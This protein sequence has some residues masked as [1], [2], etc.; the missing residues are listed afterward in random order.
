MAHQGFTEAPSRR[1][2]RAYLV[3]WAVGAVGALGYLATLA[4][5]PEQLAPVPP[6]KVVQ[7]NPGLEAATQALAEVGTIKQTVDSL[8]RNV[9][10]LKDSV[11]QRGDT[12]KTLQSRLAALEEKVAAIPNGVAT[13][14]VPMTNKQKLAEKAQEKAQQKAAAAAK[15]NPPKAG[16]RVI[17]ITE[18]PAG[19]ITPTTAVKPPIETGSITQPTVVFGEAV[20]T[21]AAELYAVQLDVA[22]SIDV[23]RHRWDLLVERY[24]ATLAP[25]QPRIVAPRTQ[26]APYRLV[27][28]PLTSAAEAKSVCGELQ[29]QIPACSTTDFGGEPL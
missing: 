27:A 15:A 23:L 13:S 29:A 25:L 5:Q 3:I 16:A 2:I 6:P 9:G 10:E 8:Q 22:P 1:F 24:G 4:W 28:G 12:D 19:T 17:T 21:R 18:D 26:G 7:A 20:V 11:E 14:S